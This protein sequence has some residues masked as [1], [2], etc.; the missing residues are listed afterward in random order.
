[1][2]AYL[3][4]TNNIHDSEYD[5]LSNNYVA[6]R[7][8]KGVIKRTAKQALNRKTQYYN[9]N[10]LNT[11]ALRFEAMKNTRIFIKSHHIFERC[12][13]NIISHSHPIRFRK[14]EKN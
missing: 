9:K 4:I 14:I 2:L 5:R 3:M 7:L 11:I 6:K 8:L 13:K 12:I 1:M 10:A